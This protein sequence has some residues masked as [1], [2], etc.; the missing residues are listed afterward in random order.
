MM[1]PLIDLR[2][3]KLMGL[4]ALF[5]QIPLLIIVSFAQVADTYARDYFSVNEFPNFTYTQN[6]LFYDRA[7]L[8]DSEIK[9]LLLAQKE[10]RTSSDSCTL[11]GRTKL[12]Q[13]TLLASKIVTRIISYSNLEGYISDI[14]VCAF[15]GLPF[16]LKFHLTGV[17]NGIIFLDSRYI[18]KASSEDEL[19]FIIAHEIAHLT[20]LHHIRSQ[21]YSDNLDW[22]RQNMIYRLD[23][24]F[25]LEA[26][27]I[28]L[29]LME[30]AGY[31]P[32]KSLAV[33][34]LFPSSNGKYSHPTEKMRV[35]NVKSVLGN[36]AQ[37]TNSN[38]ISLKI[39]LEV[40]VAMAGKLLGAK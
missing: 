2:Q 4:R 6:L 18:L 37:P 12:K 20:L 39:K 7:N 17:K 31:D 21:A 5:I 35:E 13:A 40:V 26:D 34:N 9:Y 38:K 25:E 1:N 30:N 8:S 11:P 32:S 36:F 24:K 3:P 33:I 10:W 23:R 19:A 29:G 16:D 15:S 14:G 22:D 27:L 28:A